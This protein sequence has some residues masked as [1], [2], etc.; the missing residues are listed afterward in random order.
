[1]FD[2]FFQCFG[3]PNADENFEQ[4]KRKAPHAQR[5]E[6]IV[7]IHNAHKHCANLSKTDLFYLIDGDCFIYDNFEFDYSFS[8]SSKCYLWLARDPVYKINSTYGSIKLFS[9]EMVLSS[10]NWGTTS[11]WGLIHL[12]STGTIVMR[13]EVRVD[14]VASEHR[15]NT[16]P[17]NTWRTVFREYIKQKQK[18]EQ[19]TLSQVLLKIFSSRAT[20]E[21]PG[22]KWYATQGA[23]AA[24]DFFNKNKS[25]PT[26]LMVINDYKAMQEMFNSF[27]YLEHQNT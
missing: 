5:V 24:E 22:Y 2:V 12:D 7:G 19:T 10:Q 20:P 1:M 17:F 16:T 25:Q 14:I 13:S 26:R 8:D 21:D 11:P 4:L 6:G 23:V 27:N 18:Y 15:Y 9:K 3:E